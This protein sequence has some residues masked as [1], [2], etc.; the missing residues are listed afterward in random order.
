MGLWPYRIL[1]RDEEDIKSDLRNI[2]QHFAE[3]SQTF[4]MIIFVPNA[5]KYLSQLF[6]EIFDSSFNTN[7]VTVRRASTVSKDNRLK[8]VIF[9]KKWL[10]D[11][12]RHVDVLLR[13]MRYKLGIR[14]T[15]IGRAHV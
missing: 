12:M 3:K 11:V 14:Q 10:A 15:K 4:D 5:G 6:V 7:F 2:M 8:K 1:K 9:K 13:L